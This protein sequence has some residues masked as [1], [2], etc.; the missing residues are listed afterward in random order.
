LILGAQY[1]YLLY[2]NALE[3]ASPDLP[4]ASAM[5]SMTM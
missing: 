2:L 3:Y 5:T 1:R 4:P